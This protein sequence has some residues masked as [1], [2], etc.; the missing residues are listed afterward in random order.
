M[1]GQPHA[2]RPESPSERRL[3]PLTAVLPSDV[4]DY[5]R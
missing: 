1:P 5:S 2:P 4:P 3:D